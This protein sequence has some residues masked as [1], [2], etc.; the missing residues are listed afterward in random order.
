MSAAT[1]RVVI[2][3]DDNNLH[4]IVELDTEIGLGD[5]D[6]REAATLAGEAIAIMVTQRLTRELP[7]I[8]KQTR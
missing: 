3:V 5:L 7:H 2:D 4:T 8:V 6:V 1:I